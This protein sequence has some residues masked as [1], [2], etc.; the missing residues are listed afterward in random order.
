MVGTRKLRKAWV[1]LYR[2]KPGSDKELNAY[3]KYVMS[4]MGVKVR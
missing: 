2:V 3:R 4:S 1:K